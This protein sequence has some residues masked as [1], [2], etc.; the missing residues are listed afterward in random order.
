MNTL[1]LRK[2]VQVGS[3]EGPIA[4]LVGSANPG[5][6]VTLRFA[7][8]LPARRP[9]QRCAGDTVVPNVFDFEAQALRDGAIVEHVQEFTFPEQPS[10]DEMRRRLVPVWEGL[11]V[12][13]LGVLPNG[14]P[15]DNKPKL[16]VQFTAITPSA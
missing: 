2:I 10:L 8:W 6:P 9:Y 14:A 5:G 7:F 13:S 4:A 15:Q 1:E 3:S 12:D 16:A 11:T